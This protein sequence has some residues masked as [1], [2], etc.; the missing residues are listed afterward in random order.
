MVPATVT[1]SYAFM[2]PVATPP[3]AI[4]Y[5]AAKLKPIQMVCE[6]LR[7]NIF[8]YINTLYTI[9]DQGWPTHELYLRFRYMWFDGN[10]GR[11]DV[12]YQYVSRMGE[13]Y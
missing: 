8:Q 13:R 6:K 9:P 7:I 3:N 12:R 1:C 5:S 11:C 4:V 10:S 2:L